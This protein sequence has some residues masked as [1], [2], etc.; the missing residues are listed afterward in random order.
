MSA[1][2]S[3]TLFLQSTVPD[4]RKAQSRLLSNWPSIPIEVAPMAVPSVLAALRTL[5]SAGPKVRTRP[6]SDAVVCT[7]QSFHIVD[8][9]FRAPLLV[10][11]DVAAGRGKG[12]GSDGT[13]DVQ[14]LGRAIKG[15]TGV[16]EV[17]I[18]SGV[19]GVRA[20]REHGEPRRAQ[21]PI[22]VFFGAEDGSVSVRAA[23]E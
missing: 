19:D 9:P 18:F 14:M 15:L 2:L 23:R 6:D 22:A 7:D 3:A 17:G 16:L 12:D 11:A 4:Y 5:G 20:Q 13:W 21:K 1:L 8:A 10:S